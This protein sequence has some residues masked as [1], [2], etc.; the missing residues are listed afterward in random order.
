MEPRVECASPARLRLVL[1]TALLAALPAVVGCPKSDNPLDYIRDF[2][3]GKKEQQR[4]AVEELLL[5]YKKAMP[6]V[7]E[8]VKS[9]NPN[10]RKGCAEFLS[11]VRRMESLETLGGMIDDPDRDVRL[12]VIEA[13]A[14]LSQVWKSKAVELLGHA[15]EGSDAECVTKAGEGL[16]DMEYEA[17]TQFLLTQMQEG[18]GV[19]RVYAARLL[20]EMEGRV[21]FT[22]PILEGLISDDAAV[23]EAAQANA[24]VLKDR[25]V[26]PL[27]EFIRT[28]RKTGRAE[29]VL[30]K[31]RDALREELDVVLDSM[32]AEKILAALGHIADQ[33]S[34]E[35]LNADMRDSKL[36]SSWRVAAARALALAAL[37]PRSSP[38]QS[39]GIVGDLT[40]VVKD[41]GEDK[42]IRIGAAIALCELKQEYGV[43]FLLDELEGFEEA[44]KKEN[45]SDERVD[46]LT[47]LRIGAQEALVEAG[48]FVVPFLETRLATASSPTIMWAGAKTLGELGRQEAVPLLTTY[49]TTQKSPVITV[50]EAG[51]LSGEGADADWEA[52]TPEQAAEV[53]ARLEV[54][55]YP[56]YV[57]WTSALALSRIG[58]SEAVRQLR[59]GERA[60]VA[61]LGRLA[62]SKE[63]ADYYRRA[64]VLD[65]LIRHH[66]DVLFYIRRAL[67]TL[68]ETPEG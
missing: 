31:I 8:A 56:D 42:R 14:K 65:E 17:A 68:G 32:R 5:M 10:V 25:I 27:V 36:E 37:S 15:F 18:K 12:K 52:L 46:D 21:E 40:D 11:R 48:D 54:F 1:L 22:R 7:K 13:V 57:R 38:S 3:S 39:A 67:A 34:I 29:Q 28:G 23:R 66:E 20:Y 59:E 63:G 49:L 43:K 26:V 33:E 19:Q 44:I 35:R 58:G 30:E 4:R 60:E 2:E 62:K 45:I 9:E 16:R 53:R 51:R 61:F 47:A 41:E 24:M 55:E 64:A 6:Q 50:D